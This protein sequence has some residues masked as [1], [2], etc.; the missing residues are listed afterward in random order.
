M[1]F[2]FSILISFYER[3]KIETN[4]EIKKKKE[5]GTKGKKSE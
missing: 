3:K 4:Y 1:T 5:K 2:D